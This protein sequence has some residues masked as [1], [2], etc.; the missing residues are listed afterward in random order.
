MKHLANKEKQLIARESA[1]ILIEEGIED[2]QLAKQKAVKRLG[3]RPPH[4]LPRNE[5]IENAVG[6]YHRLFRSRIQD[7]HIRKLRS[8]ALKAMT[9]LELFS[10]RLVGN[11][12]DGSAG[13]HSP[14]VIYLSAENPEP[15]VISF[16]NAKFPFAQ[17]SR[18]RL[19]AG[20]QTVYPV[21]EFI[22]D[23][24]KIEAHILAATLF[25]E[26]VQGRKSS[27]QTATMDHVRKILDHDLPADGR[28]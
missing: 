28:D 6:E 8:V 21:I 5:E 19:I 1:K 18:R 13:Q 2:F 27:L 9:F 20:K 16:L 7:L 23:G 25:R 15:V 26:C 4:P 24:I 10:P 22:L 14:V 11:V 17:S 12:V 3:L